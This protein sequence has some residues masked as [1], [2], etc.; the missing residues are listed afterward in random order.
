[1]LSMKNKGNKGALFLLFNCNLS[2][3]NGKDNF[4]DIKFK[5]RYFKFQIKYVSENI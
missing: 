3:K 1:M 5:Y 2:F 4:E